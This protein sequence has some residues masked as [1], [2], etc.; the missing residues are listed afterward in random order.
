MD[1]FLGSLLKKAHMLRCAS[2]SE[3]SRTQKAR[4]ASL[5][6]RALPLNLLEQ[7]VRLF[8]LFLTL[9]QGFWS[10]CG[11]AGRR[12]HVFRQPYYKNRLL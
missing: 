12:A 2:A 6:L 7:T 4:S 5:P 9:C 8:N 1:E 3:C 10:A 11:R